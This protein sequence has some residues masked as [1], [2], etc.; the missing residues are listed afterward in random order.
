[1]VILFASALLSSFH[2]DTCPRCIARDV[3]GGAIILQKMYLC[4]NIALRLVRKSRIQKIPLKLSS[5]A[6]CVSCDY[7]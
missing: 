6:L 3:C 7:L 4:D 5:I 1:M 2:L